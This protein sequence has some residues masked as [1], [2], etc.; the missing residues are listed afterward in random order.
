MPNFDQ[1]P[2]PALQHEGNGGGLCLWIT[3]VEATG[4]AKK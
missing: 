1:E 2:I 4:L 3:L